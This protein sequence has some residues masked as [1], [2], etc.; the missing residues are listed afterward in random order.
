MIEGMLI[1]IAVL[2]VVVLVLLALLF[3]RRDGKD[4]LKVDHLESLEKSGERMERGLKEEIARI[5][6]EAGLNA[7]QGREEIN[8]SLKRFGD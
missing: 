6:E 3:S 2:L 1:L 7:L 4:Q 8:S 5:R